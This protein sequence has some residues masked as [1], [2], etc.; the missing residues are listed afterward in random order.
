MRTVRR[1]LFAIGLLFVM[2]CASRQAVRS[3]DPESQDF[4][5]KARY[6]ISKNERKSFLAFPGQEERKVWIEDFWRKRDPDPATE[7]NEFRVEYLRRIDE[8]TRLFKE[9]STPGWLCD[10]GYLYVTLGPPD[11]RETYPRGVTFYGAPTE[12]WY[13]GFFPVVFIDDNW[14]GNYRL[15]PESAAQIGEINKTQVMLR[16]NPPSEEEIAASLGLEIAKVKDGEA[17]IRIKLPYKDIWLKAE[18]NRF[19]TTLEVEAAA[20][21]SS[22]KTVW[23]EKKS[24]PLSFEKD[25][26]LKV[27]RQDFLIEI[28]VRLSAGEYSLKIA[29]RNSAGGGDPVQKKEKL[30]L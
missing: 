17:V 9:G 18:G 14:T 26:Y 15:A 1:A 24:Y 16:P 27:I 30:V 11:N 2:A 13:Y 29:L 10:R 6:L 5:S 7:A 21:D 22:G 8:A 3:L 25:E 19:E 28:P 23:Q 12:I 4:L 20:S